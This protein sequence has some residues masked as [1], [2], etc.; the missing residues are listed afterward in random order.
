MRNGKIR[1]GT[2]LMGLAATMTM[3]TAAAQN[4]HKI[5]VPAGTRIL[6]FRKETLPWSPWR[7]M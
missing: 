1:T 5:T 6:M 7:A 3:I 2:L 4:A